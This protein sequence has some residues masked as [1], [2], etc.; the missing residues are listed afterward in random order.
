MKIIHQIT[1]LLLSLYLLGACNKEEISTTL[2]P[3]QED[4]LQ[5][6]PLGDSRV[7]GNRPDYESYRYELWK[8][9]VAND[10]PIDFVGTRKDEGNYGAFQGTE[11]DRDHEGTGGAQT[12]DILQI[13]E[14]ITP[15]NTPSI[16]LLGIGGNDLLDG[17]KTVAQ[18]ISNIEKI[19]Q[20]L[21]SRNEHITIFLEQI[22]PAQTNFMTEE[23]RN[24]LNQFNAQ[25]LVLGDAQTTTTS[26]VVVIDMAANWSDEYM[27]DVVHYNEVGAKVV[28]D[29]Y[30]EEISAT[31]E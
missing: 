11:F 21:Q 17:K 5:I 6:L 15:E 4:V 27:A 9:F 26:K 16:V 22:A 3:L 10:W 7:E 1:I 19:I 28:A 2:P 29:R 14:A 31:L 18:T 30:F 20:L 8:N 25:I 12:G 23:L 24:T 13:L